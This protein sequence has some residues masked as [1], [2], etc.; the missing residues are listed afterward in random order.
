MY[1]YVYAYIITY[2][3]YVTY[4]E[5]ISGPNGTVFYLRP[6]V[7]PTKRLANDGVFWPKMSGGHPGLP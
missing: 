3:T 5:H 4:N 6:E 7:L 1:I 2:M